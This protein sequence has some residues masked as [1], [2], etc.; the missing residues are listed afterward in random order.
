MMIDVTAFY[1]GASA[2]FS[3]SRKKT[4]HVNASTWG[5]YIH[6]FSSALSPIKTHATNV[7]VSCM[8][9][10][11]LHIGQRLHK[12]LKTDSES[13]SV[14]S[15]TSGQ[16]PSLYN[17]SLWGSTRLLLYE[18]LPVWESVDLSLP[19]KMLWKE[20]HVGGRHAVTLE[21]LQ[22]S[23]CVRESCTHFRLLKA[24]VNV[25]L[26]TVYI[27]MELNS[28]TWNSF[29]PKNQILVVHVDLFMCLYLLLTG[30]SK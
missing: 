5:E 6:R 26:T 30:Q 21:R 18:G 15:N 13:R 25:S 22:L 1:P 2:C 10:V 20:M 24:Q 8:L 27:Q 3:L 9:K 4:P 14:L 11:L 12:L 29:S 7:W 17:N 23:C 19:Y 28:S 16:S